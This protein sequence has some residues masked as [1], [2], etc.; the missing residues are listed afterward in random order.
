MKV[1]ARVGRRIAV[2]GEIAGLGADQDFVTMQLA[3]FDYL[4]EDPS[5]F[6]SER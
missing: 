3:R 2:K 1:I 4:L 6:L 5:E